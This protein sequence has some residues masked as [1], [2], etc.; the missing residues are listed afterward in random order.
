MS[1]F[2][3]SSLPASFPTQ[4]T[5]RLHRTRESRLHYA[6]QH[7]LLKT[8]PHVPYIKSPCPWCL[9]ALG[10]LPDIPTT[11]QPG[12]GNAGESRTHTGKLKAMV[13]WDQMGKP[14]L[15]NEKQDCKQEWEQE[16]MQQL[17]RRHSPKPWW[18]MLTAPLI[19][20]MVFWVLERKAPDEFIPNSIL[21]SPMA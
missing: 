9:R 15:N 2:S 21:Y 1:L 10:S 14:S 5:G 16:K 18:S 13:G 11:R 6:P 19:V 17:P 3:L 8:L 4:T 7:W 12:V 20:L